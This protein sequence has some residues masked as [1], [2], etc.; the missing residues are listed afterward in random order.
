[1]PA[2]K[3]AETVVDLNPDLP[4]ADVIQMPQPEQASFY[5]R[6][7]A[8]LPRLNIASASS[9]GRSSLPTPVEPESDTVLN[10]FRAFLS[11]NRPGWLPQR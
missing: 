4:L 3:Q 6:N 9:Y 10:L 7:S 8:D 5:T 11:K 1:M 2:N